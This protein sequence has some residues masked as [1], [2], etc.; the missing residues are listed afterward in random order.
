MR[1]NKDE[2]MS[3]IL[4]LFLISG[5]SSYSLG[6]RTMGHMESQGGD[7]LCLVEHVHCWIA[8]TEIFARMED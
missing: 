8:L 6:R 3:G 2:P 5:T 7:P 1:W 4:V